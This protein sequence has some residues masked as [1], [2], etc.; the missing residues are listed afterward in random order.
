MP[1]ENCQSEI[2]QRRVAPVPLHRC[3]VI[4]PGQEQS[5]VWDA[6]VA[7]HP[8]ATVYHTTQ[9]QQ[10]LETSFSH[11][12]GRFLVLRDGNSGAIRAG[13]PVYFVR[14]RLLGDRFVSVPFASYCDPLLSS[15]D[16]LSAF[17]ESIPAQLA[18][19]KANSF[20]LRPRRVAGLLQATGVQMANLY[21][22]HCLR[23]NRSPE[24][25]RK[26]FSRT[27]VR[28]W[29]NKA[30]KSGVTVR[31]GSEDDDLRCFCALLTGA[32]RKLG[33]PPMPEQ[34]FSAM[35]QFLVP[36]HLV[37]MTAIH[38]DRPVASILVLRWGETCALEY[39]ADTDEGRMIGAGQLLYWE[40]VRAACRQGCHSLSFGRTSP[41]N[42]GLLDYKRRWGTIEEDLLVFMLPRVG[43][44]RRALRERAAAYRLCRLVAAHAPTPM[45]RWLGRF[46]YRHLG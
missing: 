16:D 32:R 5:S 18:G 2:E 20:E 24:E 27:C 28:Q 39:A 25:L 15:P 43:L 10:V 34:F 8:D 31:A 33:L 26:G 17:M 41:L 45:Y 3:E 42:L 13:L 21:R 1:I 44:R 22:H 46:V 36:G 23:L 9:W 7:R 38:R 29:L 14:S 37:L 19:A 12:R 11:I 6:F 30:E 40:T 4:S 35:R